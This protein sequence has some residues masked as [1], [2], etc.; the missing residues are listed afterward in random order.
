MPRGDQT[1]PNG[2]G[3]MS[4]RG[5]GFCAG[6]DMPGYANPGMFGRG[7]RNARMGVDV[8]RDMGFMPAAG[9]AGWATQLTLSP[10]PWM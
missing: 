1:G 6:Y 2:T 4:G 7:M 8:E 5:A 10:I 9:T 3:P